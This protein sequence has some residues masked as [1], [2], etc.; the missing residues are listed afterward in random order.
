MAVDQR[1][2]RS[3]LLQDSHLECVRSSVGTPRISSAEHVVT[4]MDGDPGLSFQ[5]APSFSC[6]VRQA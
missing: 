2:D 5:R 1:L 6:I 4:V 3:C